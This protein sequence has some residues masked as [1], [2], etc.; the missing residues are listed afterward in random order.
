MWRTH[1]PCGERESLSNRL[2]MKGQEISAGIYWKK[3]LTLAFAAAALRSCMY[4][5]NIRKHQTL[6]DN[7]EQTGSFFFAYF[8]VGDCVKHLFDLGGRVCWAAYW[9]RGVERIVTERGETR[10]Q[11]VFILSERAQKIFNILRIAHQTL[12]SINQNNKQTNKK[13]THDPEVRV[14]GLHWNELHVSGESLVQ[15]EVV[16]P[17]HGHQVTEPLRVG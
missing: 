16:P 12:V 10:A 4:C 6:T 1:A 15:P 8:L 13:D 5:W 14:G 2:N 9:S 17:L 7:I 11:Q 3:R